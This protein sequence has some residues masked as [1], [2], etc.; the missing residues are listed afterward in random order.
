[1]FHILSATCQMTWYYEYFCTLQHLHIPSGG[2]RNFFL[3]GGIEGA[4]CD[5]EGA[6]IQKVAENGWFWLCFSSDGGKMGAEPLTGGA[7]APMPPLMPPLHIPIFNIPHKIVSRQHFSMIR[8]WISTLFV[9]MF[10]STCD[11]LSSVQIHTYKYHLELEWYC[12][13]G[14]FCVTLI[15]ALF[16]HFWASAKLKAHESVYFVCRS[17]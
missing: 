10:I 2:T 4:K 6:K 12:K 8:I 3:W 5:S 11:T 9:I 14:N 16:T 15:F 1:M 13:S 17:M 7:N